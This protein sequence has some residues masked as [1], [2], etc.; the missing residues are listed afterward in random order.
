MVKMRS[1]QEMVCNAEG[2]HAW[3]IIKQINYKVAL[4]LNALDKNT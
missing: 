2:V 3:G 1:T 4:P